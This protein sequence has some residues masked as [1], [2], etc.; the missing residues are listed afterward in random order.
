MRM[1]ELVNT[2]LFGLLAESSQKVTNE[3]M[4]NAYGEFMEKVKAVGSSNDNATTLRTLNITRIELV[5][6]ETV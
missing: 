3:E 2:R 4:Q 5:A 1:D 6:L